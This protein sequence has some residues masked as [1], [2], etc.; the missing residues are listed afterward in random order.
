LAIFARRSY[1]QLRATFE[2]YQKKYHKDITQVIR[3]EF[4]GD[5]K[6]AYLVLIS[7]VRDRPTFFAERLRKAISGLGTA[8][9]TLIRV[10][11]TRSEI[12]LVQIKQRYQQLYNRSLAQD[13]SG[14]TSGDY[15]RILLAIV[16]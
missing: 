4:S 2:E 5:T 7:C 13:V 14:D 11:V 15:R 1:Y 9:S 10:I 6:D 16:K 3:S 12:D 8:D